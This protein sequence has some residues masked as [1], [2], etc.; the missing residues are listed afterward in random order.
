[1]PFTKSTSF[2][3]K[4]TKT[5]P[6]PHPL[7][8]QMDFNRREFLLSAPAIFLLLSLFLSSAEALN[9]GIDPSTGDAVVFISKHNSY[10][11]FLSPYRFISPLNTGLIFYEI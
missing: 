1:M 4:Q 10:A 5:H 7:Q 8:L 2:L 3:Y 11:I 9:I 6:T